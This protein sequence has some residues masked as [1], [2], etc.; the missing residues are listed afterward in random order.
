[1]PQGNGASQAFHSKE[2]E[3]VRPYFRCHQKLPQNY[4]AQL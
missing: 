4:D 2:D 1:M 3:N